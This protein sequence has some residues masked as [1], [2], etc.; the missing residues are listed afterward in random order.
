MDGKVEM[1]PT[2]SIPAGVDY[3]CISKEFFIPK[4]KVYTVVEV[5]LST[6]V[7]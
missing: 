6:R 3:F 1:Y 5:Y 2:N 7:L 4:T